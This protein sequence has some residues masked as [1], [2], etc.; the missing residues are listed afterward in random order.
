M[1]RARFDPKAGV[2]PRPTD[3][4]RDRDAQ[5]LAIP[6]TA[7]DL[8]DKT[9]AEAALIAELNT[10]DGWPSR[11]AAELSFS[12]AVKASSVNAESIRI[13]AAGER[14]MEKVELEPRLD[15]AD[16]LVVDPPHEGWLRGGEYFAIALGGEGG[17]VGEAGEPVV[18]DAAMYFLRLEE[19]LLGHPN[20]LP[21]AE[22]EKLEKIRLELQPFFAHAETLGI[23]RA[24]I[25]ALWSFTIT[26]SPEVLMD[27]QLGKM[28]LP[29]DFLRDPGSGSIDLPLRDDDTEL[30][31][32]I[33]RDL[34]ALDGFALS[35]DLLFEISGPIDPTTLDDRAVRVFQVDAAA[36]TA[37]EVPVT[38][39]SKYGDTGVTITLGEKPLAPAAE[40]LVVV[41]DSLK[42]A[43]GR[44]VEAMLPGVLAM[45]ETPVYED[46]AST[47]G[48]VDGESAA[49]VE[50]VRKNTAGAL[51]VLTGLGLVD[52][53]HV[54]AAWSFRTQSAV[55]PLLRA[56]D[57][58]EML[59]LSPDPL[60]IEE[61]ST[62]AAGADFALA[63]L[64]LLRVDHVV[65][66][67]IL[68]PSFV[69]PITRK[70]RPNGAWEPL[71]VGFTMAI[72]RGV[73]EDQPLKVAIFGHGLMTERHFV[74]AVADQLA[75]EGIATIAIDF[76]FHG[77]RTAC[78]WSGPLCLVNPLDQSGELICPNPCE[79]NSMC[80]PDGR[81]VDNAG[82]GN[83]LS[84]WPLVNYPQASGG[85]FM[86][87]ENMIG[88]RDHFYQSL[89]DLS[90]L[91]RS[92][93]TGDWKSAVGYAID[94]DVTYFGQSLGGI[95]GSI[96]TSANPE[97]RRAVLNVPGA[98]LI[99][100]FRESTV[101]AP[102]M[103]A[104]LMRESIT[105]GTP[106]HELVINVARWI[107]DAVD[108]Q[109]FADYLLRT[110]IDTGAAMGERK[111]L[112]QMA[113]LDLVINNENTL[114]L[115][116]LSGVQREDYLAEHGFIVLPVEPAYLRG[117]NDIAAVLSQ[118]VLP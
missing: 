14:G 113:T 30:R 45:L 16:H 10:R 15:R 9:A 2:I 40:H 22:A 19:S 64:S 54:A 31:A 1:I 115:E 25:V 62:F 56:R 91:L 78:S 86:Q 68:V 52:R 102:Q 87:V 79:N 106:D 104:F 49:R 88:T 101:F 82:N 80:A 35:A 50:F 73:D 107:M 63:A 66:G 23:E 36:N 34:R 28:P 84:T 71:K 29:S 96:F 117:M 6:A 92:L 26:A 60:D 97:I 94:P 4:L 53:A 41:A 3:I 110:N 48:S 67:A 43:R 18:A 8:A 57:A 114:I 76:P 51:G 70:A 12:G 55:E 61:R 77:D 17:L 13:F 5:K 85:A 74:L 108:P 98:D 7:E 58:A 11:T 20:A 75:A 59:D 24:D 21:E 46:G 100:L 105:P 37:L 95:L 93:K 83:H 89:T 116:R 111:M 112:I 39:A 32:N 81:C 47:I 69:D 72:P 103:D 38:L 65:E 33:K 99:D 27:K 118:G 109:T 90:A 42:D 44:S